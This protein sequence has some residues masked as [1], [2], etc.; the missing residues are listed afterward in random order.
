M[1]PRAMP[2]TTPHLSPERVLWSVAF[3]ISSFPSSPRFTTTTPS[4][5]T[6]APSSTAFRSS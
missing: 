1:T 2:P 4:M 6:V 5:A 3:W